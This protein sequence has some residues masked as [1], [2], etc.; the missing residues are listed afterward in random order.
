MIYFA[1]TI[2]HAPVMDFLGCSI[3]SH[4]W[5]WKYMSIGS[6]QPAYLVERLRLTSRLRLASVS[7]KRAV[8]SV[9]ARHT[10]KAQEA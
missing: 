10:Q 3:R 9:C 4:R 6:V 1:N 5:L 8:R 2:P 7:A